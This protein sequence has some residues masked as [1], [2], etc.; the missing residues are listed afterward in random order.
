M[1][2]STHRILTTHTGSLPRTPTVLDLLRR[3]TARERVDSQVFDKAVHDGV[4][5]VVAKQTAAGIDVANDGEMGK[6]SFATYN[7]P[8]LSGFSMVPAPEGAAFPS[9][10]GGFEAADYPEFF[11]RWAFNAGVAQGQ[12]PRM[13][14]AC[15]GPIRYTGTDEL[16]RDIK[17]LLEAARVSGATEPFMSAVPSTGVASPFG[18][19]LNRYYSS[20]EEFDAAMADAM[21]VEY[22][23]IV[24]AG[25]V[26]QLA[27]LAGGAS[28]WCRAAPCARPCWG[29]KT[30]NSSQRRAARGPL[31]APPLPIS[32]RRP[33]L[34][35]RPLERSGWPPAR[36]RSS[37]SIGHSMICAASWQ[38]RW[39]AL[40]AAPWRWRSTT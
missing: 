17:N 4:L 33:S 14:L 28:S 39:P 1:K 27:R 12:P 6:V 2:R 31:R 23:A 11:E 24:N 25:I 20:Q 7:I 35:R 21:R 30:T 8:R 36:R 18:G 22:E 9:H 37:C 3:R 13:V 10:V 38:R 32:G 16:Q 34:I 5:E 26:L 40:R 29:S 15:T 19:P